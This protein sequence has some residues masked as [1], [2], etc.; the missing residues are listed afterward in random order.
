MKKF[1]EELKERWPV[2]ML[3]IIFVLCAILIN[4]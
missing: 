2:A 4:W 1:V 3:S